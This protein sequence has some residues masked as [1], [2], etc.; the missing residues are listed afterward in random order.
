[1]RETRIL[2]ELDGDPVADED[3]GLLTEVQVEEATDEADAATLVA[4]LEAGSD[5]DWTSVL[6]PLASPRTDVVVQIT[7]GDVLYR[8]EGQSTEASWSVDAQGTSQLTVK[9]VDRTLELDAE[10]KVVAWPGTSDSAIAQAIFTSQGFKPEVEATPA[11]PDPDV[12]VVLQRATDWGFVRAL[13]AKW[14]YAAYL[15]SDGSRTTG[16]F[17]PLDP[18]ADPQAE[19]SLGFGG[20]SLAARVEARLVAGQHVKATRIPALSDSPQ[21]GEGIGTADAQG[22]LPL[23][24]QATVLLAP[25]DL[26]GEVDP[27]ATAAGVAD[28]SAF[29][30]R[31]TVEVDSDIVGLVVR[32]RRTI[33]VRGLGSTLSGRYLVERV[34][35]RVTADR[36]VQALTLTRNALGLSGDEP[37]GGGRLL[38]GLL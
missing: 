27:A 25:S 4:P 9:A 35:H 19:L 24:G 6:D 17:H 18:L 1:M 3:F 38:G 37:F 5:G 32:A 20:D 36:H 21:T 22:A 10:E 28:R 23:G 15:E 14:G 8:F 26:D 16:H 31:M 12:H 29:A 30:V 2:V 13:A 33:L 34:R 7:R 11:A